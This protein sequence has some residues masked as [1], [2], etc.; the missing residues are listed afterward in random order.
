MQRE[1]Q[2]DREI[3]RERERSGLEAHRRVWS[4][5][6]FRERERER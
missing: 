4:R 3:F 1:R 2:R 5:P 6:E